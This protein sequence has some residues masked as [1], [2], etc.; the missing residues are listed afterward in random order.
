MRLQFLFM[1]IF[2]AQLGANLPL[3]ASEDPLFS[4]SQ[5]EPTLGSE[6]GCQ[7]RI[8]G[9]NCSFYSCGEEHKKCGK[10]G[11]FTGFGEKYCRKFLFD[12]YPRFTQQGQLWLEQNALC[13]QEQLAILPTSTSCSQI[14]RKSIRVHAHCYLETE[15]CRLPWH[16]LK[17]ILKVVGRNLRKPSVIYQSLLISKGCRRYVGRILRS[18]W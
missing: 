3:L 1:I 9:E 8:S 7:E 14:Y 17:L 13:L 12:Y 2:S 5:T 6:S 16:D 11:Y 15:V 18:I 4:F 10:G